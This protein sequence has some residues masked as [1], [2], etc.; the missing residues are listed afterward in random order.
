M[1]TYLANQTLT[2]IQIKIF[3]IVNICI[4]LE[5]MYVIF[6]INVCAILQETDMLCAVEIPV[7]YNV[8][9]FLL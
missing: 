9:A 5:L 8:T 1:N 6:K 7:E 3:K 4:C 2:L